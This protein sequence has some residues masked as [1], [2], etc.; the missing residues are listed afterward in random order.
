MPAEYLRGVAISIS[1]ID[2]SRAELVAKGV[3]AS[4][5]GKAQSGQMVT[6]HDPE[7]SGL[8][9]MQGAF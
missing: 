4:D 6:F 1:D 5:V 7:G 8:I 9:L 2:T 3:E